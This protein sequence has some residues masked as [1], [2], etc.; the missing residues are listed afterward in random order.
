MQKLENSTLQKLIDEIVEALKYEKERGVLKNDQLDIPFIISAL[1]QSFKNKTD[2]YENLIN[3]LSRYCDYNI[4]ITESKNDYNGIID[5]GINLVKWEEVNEY[6]DACIDTYECPDYDYEIR[7]TYDERDW[8]YCECTPDMPDYREDKQCCGHGCDATFCEFELFK[9]TK[10]IRDS[11]HSDEH[12]YWEFEDDFYAD[13]EELADKKSEEDKA[14]MIKIL[15]ETIE[16]ATK[17]LAEL[18]GE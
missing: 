7:F 16:E 10:I 2:K 11:W 4:E 13:D 14:K 17:K 5:V 1:Y 12:A 15:K 6:G 3:D 8:G 18:E 9:V